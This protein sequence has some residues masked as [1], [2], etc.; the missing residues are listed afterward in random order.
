LGNRRSITLDTGEKVDRELPV[1]PSQ[2]R[3]EAEDELQ[4][5]TGH[6]APN[7]DFVEAYTNNVYEIFK[8]KSS[9]DDF[10]K[11][12]EG[13]ES[14]T[15][16][17]IKNV[18]DPKAYDDYTAGIRFLWGDKISAAKRGIVSDAAATNAAQDAV[19]G[20]SLRSLQEGII[21]RPEGAV[22]DVTQVIVDG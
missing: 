10:A 15:S 18:D 3:Q 8:V 19:E 2:T 11:I 13:L 12:R 7:L 21:N 17:Y 16:N 4:F 6:T 1:M 14:L 5:P 22:P 9:P 20:Q